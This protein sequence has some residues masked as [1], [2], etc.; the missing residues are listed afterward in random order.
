MITHLAEIGPRIYRLST[1]FPDVMPGGLAFNQFLVDAEDPL[2]FHTG[3]RAIFPSVAEVAARVVPLS[4]LRWISFGHVEADENGAM[5]LWLHSAPRAQS[6][7]GEL[8]CLVSLNDLA[9]RAPRALADREVLDLGG[10][11]V[12]L[13]ATPHVP[14]AW[15]SIVL[16]EETT[17][18]LFCGDLFTHTGD[19]P[20]VVESDVADPALEVERLFPGGTALTPMTGA[21]L[22]GLA[23]LEPQTLALMH[24]SSF[25]GNGAAQLK[26]L[27]DG[28]DQ[29]F[30]EACRTS[31]MPQ[32]KA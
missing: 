13:I 31:V 22:R 18:T 30:Q 19:G 26:K 7:H 10:R 32:R 12:R 8:G 14:H 9:D 4:R 21:T 16:F 5:N 25:R 1:F 28:Y 3:M 29:M 11:K 27:A 6:L 15:E 23:D 20:A 17:R 24:G 2:L